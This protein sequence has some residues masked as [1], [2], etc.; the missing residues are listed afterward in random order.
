[1][2]ILV[3]WTTKTAQDW[4]EIN[5]EFWENTPERADPTGSNEQLDDATG[6]VHAICVQGVTFNGY[7]HYSIEQ[8]E[9][10]SVEVICWSDD[11]NTTPDR[12]ASEWLFLPFQPN[13]YGAW[14]THQIVRRFAEGDSLSRLQ[15]LGVVKTSGGDIEVLPWREFVQPESKNTRHGKSATDE[16]NGTL[17][18]KRAEVR[19]DGDPW[20]DGVPEEE[21]VVNRD[22]VRVLR[23]QAAIGR[24]ILPDGTR[25]WFLTD[26]TESQT[27]HTLASGN[28]SGSYDATETGDDLGD[29]RPN[30]DRTR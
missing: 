6:W 21:I 5:A 4:T 2:K 19:G 18:A 16:Q 22:G 27:V 26:A 28:D 10:G 15:Q 3:Q 20:L 23:D 29:A 13:V 12:V 1:M 14:D 7:D 30:N 25:T 11:L 24:R 8:L 9:D 17:D